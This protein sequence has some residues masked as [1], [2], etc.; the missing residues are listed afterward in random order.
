MG[1]EGGD[2]GKLVPKG[3]VTLT[4]TLCTFDSET[5]G[6]G[7][8]CNG[9][10]HRYAV[11]VVTVDDDGC[12]RGGSRGAVVRES[13]TVVPQT[14]GEPH[15]SETRKDGIETVALLDR[16]TTK[17]DEVHTPSEHGIGHR[18]GGEEVGIV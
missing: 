9:K 5:Y 12:R 13:I 11:V 8:S 7:G 10:T 6:H 18:K 14:V 1:T 16:K 17:T 4:D 2:L 15:G 3:G